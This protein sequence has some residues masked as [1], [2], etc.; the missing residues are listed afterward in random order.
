MADRS[1][2]VQDIIDRMP[3]YW[4]RWVVAIVS[5]LMGGI[6]LLSYL[7]EYPETVDGEVSITAT[8]APVRLVAQ[9]TGRLHTLLSREANVKEGEVVAYIESGVNY[10]DYQTLKKALSE[11]SVETL[12][13]TLSLGELATPYNTYLLAKE[14]WERR[15]STQRYKAMRKNM[16]AQIEAN[17][18]VAS[19][20]RHTLH[21]KQK[22]RANIT[23][24]MQRD[25]MLLRSGIVS[26][27]EVK[28]RQNTYYTQE[29]AEANLQASHYMKQ[30]EIRNFQIE[31]ARNAMEEEE[32]LEEAYTEMQSKY[33]ILLNDLR[34]WEEKYLL[35]A[36]MSGRVD[37]LGFWRDNT[38]V[39]TA[40]EL[41]S[42]LPQRNSV[43]GEAHISSF[44]AGKVKVGQEVNIKLN[45]FPYDEF[46][47]L[48][49]R[50]TAISQLASKT[51]VKDRTIETYLVQISFPKG[52]I[53][54]FGHQLSL[55]FETKGTAEIII[56]P[57]RL[58]QRLFDNLKAKTI[59]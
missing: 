24:E 35:R 49:G 5:L 46:G 2:E 43:L 21:L 42:I 7:I 32:L 14:Q 50:V 28:A 10:S 33:N 16:Y 34:L 57:K 30:A 48:K 26:P 45:D 47:L 58:L 17:E 36:P 40:T 11:G 44:G 55:N 38:V 13:K 19:Q 41:F 3:T 25:S 6:L 18:K 8:T 20:L 15:N 59:K 9:S 52:L 56:Q 29:E 53:T 54:N 37:F 22:V 4:C 39:A 23:K 31:V 1:E 27:S 12:S 51:Q